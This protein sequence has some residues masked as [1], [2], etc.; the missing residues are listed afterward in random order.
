MAVVYSRRKDEL[1]MNAAGQFYRR[2][3]R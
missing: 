2:V 3:R 1:S